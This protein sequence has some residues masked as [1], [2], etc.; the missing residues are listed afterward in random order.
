MSPATTVPLMTFEPLPRSRARGFVASSVI[1]PSTASSYNAAESSPPPVSASPASESSPPESSFA[2]ASA[3]LS[4]MTRLP[5]SLV[6]RFK[7][8]SPPLAK[9]F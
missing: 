6:D 4:P 9:S 2:G 8:T 3:S 5:S 7:F 1:S